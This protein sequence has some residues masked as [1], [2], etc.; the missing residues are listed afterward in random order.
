MKEL[1]D[2]AVRIFAVVCLVV[3]GSAVVLV[4]PAAAQLLVPS[5]ALIAGAVTWLLVGRDGLV[6]GAFVFFAVIVGTQ[7]ANVVLTHDQQ[8]VV[9]RVEECNPSS[10]C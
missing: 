3:A 7:I 1:S 6:A 8:T 5:A 2:K 10:V 4:L 9:V